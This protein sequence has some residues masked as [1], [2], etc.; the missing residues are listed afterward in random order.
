MRGLPMIRGEPPACARERATL[1]A[2]LAAVQLAAVLHLAVVPHAV[3]GRGR[4]VHPERLPSALTA[5]ARALRALARPASRPHHDDACAFATLLRGGAGPLV[6]PPAP[7]PPPAAGVGAAPAT[8]GSA[9]SVQALH[10]LAPKQSPP[11]RA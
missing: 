9:R 4:L 3:D 10:R 6:P 1:A 11:T 8:A 7:V 5:P 2:L